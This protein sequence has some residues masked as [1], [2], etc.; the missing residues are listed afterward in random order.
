MQDSLF[1]HEIRHTYH[2]LTF[3]RQSFLWSPISL[4]YAGIRIAWFTFALVAFNLGYFLFSFLLLQ[5]PLVMV[6][7]I[8][9][10]TTHGT[11]LEVWFQEF[12]SFTTH[13]VRQMVSFLLH[14]ENSELSFLV[15]ILW[16]EQPFL[17][18]SFTERGQLLLLTTSS[19]KPNSLLYRS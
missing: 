15:L 19:L 13:N 18:F 8:L 2:E 11:V 5:C 1:L 16:E 10:N 7:K 17:A 3:S 6:W 4:Y 14:P 12:Y 9:T